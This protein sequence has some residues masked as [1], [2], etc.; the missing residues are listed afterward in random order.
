MNKKINHP[1]ITNTL[2]I[3]HKIAI[4]DKLASIPGPLTP[5]TNNPDFIPGL[6]QKI[7]QNLLANHCM[8][9]K[10]VKSYETLQ[11]EWG[12]SFPGLWFYFQMKDFLVNS[13]H[14]TKYCLPMMHVETL[15]FKRSQVANTTSLSYSWLNQLL[16][17]TIVNIKRIGNVT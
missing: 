11:S 1:L 10:R 7:I 9:G 5:I 4:T 3:W 12:K 6:H 15:C 17:W 14:K 16:I 8:D 2:N 13:K